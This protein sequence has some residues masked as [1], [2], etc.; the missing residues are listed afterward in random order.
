MKSIL[1]S[2]LL[3]GLLLGYPVSEINISENTA[4]E[5]QP[6]EY[7]VQT[8]EQ[9]EPWR[10]EVA[11]KMYEEFCYFYDNME[12]HDIIKKAMNTHKYVNRNEIGYNCVMAVDRACGITEVYHHYLSDEKV[13]DVET[14]YF[15]LDYVDY[16]SGVHFEYTKSG[17]HYIAIFQAETDYG[18]VKE[19]TRNQIRSSD[20]EMDFLN[21][22]YLN[23][24]YG[25]VD[26]FVEDL[27]QTRN[28]VSMNVEIS[29]EFDFNSDV[30]NKINKLSPNGEDLLKKYERDIVRSDA[31]V[32]INSW[33]LYA[34][35]VK[36]KKHIKI[37]LPDESI[38]LI[39]VAP[40]IS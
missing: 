15:D 20:L 23:T 22:I 14:K 36:D 24:N 26:I 33:N 19:E 32:K 38:K 1:S 25:M 16:F 7:E 11:E 13:K 37:T 21:E 35:P 28:E 27:S 9:A 34:F 8:V 40:I 10:Y 12:E 2:L 29:D 17:L 39:S 6:Q 30:Y 5:T 31:P 3:I 4:A 18:S